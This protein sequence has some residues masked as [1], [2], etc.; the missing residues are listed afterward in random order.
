MFVWESGASSRLMI[1]WA[2]LRP[3]SKT[4]Q[5][6]PKAIATT[7]HGQVA[8]LARFKMLAMRAMPV[9][10]DKIVQMDAEFKLHKSKKN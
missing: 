3:L 8:E 2:N 5:A 10:K 1:H 6:P 7:V 9:S 4:L